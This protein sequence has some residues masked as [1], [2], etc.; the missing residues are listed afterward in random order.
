MQ[1]PEIERRTS[2]IAAEAKAR[3]IPFRVTSR[4]RSISAQQKLYDAYI[5]R[6]RTGLPAARPGLSTHNYGIA[7]DAVFPDNRQAEVAAIALKH[8]M[9]WFGP[10]DKVHF[11]IFGPDRWNELLRSVGVL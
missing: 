11:D 1:I 10:K 7:F 4:Y 9:V 2:A 3:G 5:A 6:G 8:G